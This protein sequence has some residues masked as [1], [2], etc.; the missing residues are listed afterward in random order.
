L[1][2]SKVSSIQWGLVL[3]PPQ[4][5]GYC[6]E[7]LPAPRYGF[8]IFIKYILKHLIFSILPN[9]ISL[10]GITKEMFLPTKDTTT[11][12][13]KKKNENQLG[14]NFKLAL[15]LWSGCLTSLGPAS[16]IYEVEKVKM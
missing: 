9:E 11:Q 8:E 14:I 3:Y 13:K 10:C 12:K 1:V 7:Q 2:L 4:I 6:Y 16:F 15:Q 5:R